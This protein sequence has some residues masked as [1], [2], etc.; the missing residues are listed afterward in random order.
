MQPIKILLVEDQA[1]VRDA[2]AQLLDMQDDFEIIGHVANGVQAMDCVSSMKVDMVLTDIEMPEMDGLSLCQWLSDNH[3]LI[4]TTILT[5]FNRSGYIHRALEAGARGFIL[6]E[7]P[8]DELTQNLRAIAT[9][10]KVYDPQL[11]LSGLEDK[12]PLS[13]RE[14]EVLRHAELGLSTSKI[15]ASMHL[16]EGTIRNYLSESMSKLYAH[17]R[18]QAAKIAREKGWL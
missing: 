11:V 9:G 5:T 8:V 13:E 15:A 17:T 1:L 10:V 14:K 16:S 2:L 4:K 3:P 18:G 12:D 6:K 7:V